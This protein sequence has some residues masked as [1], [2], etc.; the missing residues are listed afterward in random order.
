MNLPRPWGSKSIA[1]IIEHLFTKCGK[2]M[3][4]KGRLERAHVKKNFVKCIFSSPAAAGV[5]VIGNKSR[6]KIRL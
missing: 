4:E 5:K 2:E 6:K 1:N 3:T